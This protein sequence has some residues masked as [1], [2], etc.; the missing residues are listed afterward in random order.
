MA[1][2]LAITVFAIPIIFVLEGVGGQLLGAGREQ[3]PIWEVFIFLTILSGSVFTVPL[4]YSGN[5]SIHL[6]SQR[7]PRG[8]LNKR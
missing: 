6:I 5:R 3:Q 8:L 2:G 1:F 7:L 4:F